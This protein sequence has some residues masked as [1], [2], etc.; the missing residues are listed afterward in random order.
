M[1]AM[2]GS[3]ITASFL[4][5]CASQWSTTKVQVNLHRP[6]GMQNRPTRVYFDNSLVFSN[7]E[8]KVVGFLF[9][10]KHRIRVEMDGVK[11]STQ[12]IKLA[13]GGG[14]QVLDFWLR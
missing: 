12:S 11:T 6:D 7:S 4:C 9:P 2:L 14:D 10:G 5:G 8:P 3:L 1:K 13:S